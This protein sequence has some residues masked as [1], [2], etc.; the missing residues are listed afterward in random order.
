MK[1]LLMSF[2]PSVYK[3]IS[4]QDKLIEFRS[5]YPDEETLVYMYI[6]KPCK[7][8]LGV[9]HLGKKIDMASV[10]SDSDF[11]KQACHDG[12]SEEKNVFGMPVLTFQKVSPVSL[13][14]LRTNCQGFV[15]PQSYIILDT[16]PDLKG[17]IEKHAIPFDDIIKNPIIGGYTND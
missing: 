5:R 4:T 17:F 14:D 8:I 1:T 13:E 10:D 3:R 9:V 7:Q 16:K 15:A 11:Y 6:S 12:Y 2:W